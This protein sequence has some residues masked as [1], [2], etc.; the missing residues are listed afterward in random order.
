L[1]KNTKLVKLNCA[2]NQLKNLNLA[3]NLNLEEIDV[4]ANK[5]VAD[6]TIFSHLTKLTKLEVGI[7]V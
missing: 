1:S 5:I 4:R 7:I 6:L 3:N 2:S